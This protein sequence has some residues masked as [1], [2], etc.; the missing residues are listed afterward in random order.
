MVSTL[1]VPIA[2]ASP[3]AGVVCVLGLLG[4]VAWVGWRFGPAL[5]RVTGWCCWAVAWACGSQGGYGYCVAFAVLGVLAW[6]AGT[7]W[8]ARR[9]GRWPSALSA[10]LFRRL[11]GERAR[12]RQIELPAVLIVPDRRSR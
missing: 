2:S 4:V 9:R 1:L 11:L 12:L 5:A 6:G 10:K 3:L 8:Y 7:V